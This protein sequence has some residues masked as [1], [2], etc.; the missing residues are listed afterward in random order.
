MK[1]SFLPIVNF[2]LNGF[3]LNS[4]VSHI[5]ANCILHSNCNCQSLFYSY[6]N[7]YLRTDNTVM[8]LQASDLHPPSPVFTM[9]SSILITSLKGRD[10]KCWLMKT[11][12]HCQRMVRWPLQLWDW[13]QCDTGS[14]IIL[15]AAVWL[16]TRVDMKHEADHRIQRVYQ[17]CRTYVA[18][19]HPQSS[20]LQNLVLSLLF[21]LVPLP[22]VSL[23]ASC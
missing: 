13:G 9:Q 20:A 5:P 22:H 15:L 12:G 19:Q 23:N 4:L 8:T 10:T 17:I 18:Y 14:S 6:Q 21:M 11:K 2:T 7:W 3:C 1:I 16:N